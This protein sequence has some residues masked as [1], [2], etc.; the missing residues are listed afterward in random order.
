VVGYPSLE[1]YQT[2]L[3]HPDS[4][5]ID[6][7]LKRGQIK[8]TGLGMPLVQCGGFALTYSV[9]VNTKAASQNKLTNSILRNPV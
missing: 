8:M 9:N 3:Q 1:Q 7:E 5:F 6:P 2:A 4:V